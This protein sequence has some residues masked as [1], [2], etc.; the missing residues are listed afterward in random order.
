MTQLNLSAFSVGGIML[1]FSHVSPQDD[2]NLNPRFPVVVGRVD[3]QLVGCLYRLVLWLI[4]I[5]EMGAHRFARH[6][7]LSILR[8][9]GASLCLEVLDKFKFTRAA[10]HYTWR[11]FRQSRG[12]R[13]KTKRVFTQFSP[14]D[15]TAFHWHGTASLLHY[16][17]VVMLLAVFLAAELNPFYLKVRS[18]VST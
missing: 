1:E 10:K 11:G 15:F 4:L 3:M 5:P 8:S 18:S 13:S 17:T 9:E 14:H 7:S 12:I 6:E 2:R 16:V